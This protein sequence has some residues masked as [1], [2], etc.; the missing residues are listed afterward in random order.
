MARSRRLRRVRER[1]RGHVR[2]VRSAVSDHKKAV[3]GVLLL[4]LFVSMFSLVLTQYIMSF[5]NE[6]GFEHVAV[7]S[8]FLMAALLFAIELR[9]DFAAA[10]RR[11]LSRRR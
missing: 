9:D 10:A 2:R 5:I 8:L 3:L 7:D 1:V 4:M 6:L 11:A